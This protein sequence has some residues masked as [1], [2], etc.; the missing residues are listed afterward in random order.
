MRRALNVEDCL[1]LTGDRIEEFQSVC[2]KDTYYK[3][4]DE[5]GKVVNVKLCFNEE[6]SRGNFGLFICENFFSSI[7]KMKNFFD[8]IEEIMKL[9]SSENNRMYVMRNT[10]FYL[11]IH[12]LF[13]FFLFY[14]DIICL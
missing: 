4:G 10:Y 8:R 7:E 11:M 12:F 6:L 3:E 9:E 1:K 13:T 14:L 5:N 2:E